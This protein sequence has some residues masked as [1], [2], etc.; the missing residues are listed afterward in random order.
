[1][2]AAGLGQLRIGRNKLVKWQ[3]AQGAAAGVWR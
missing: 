2:D 1:M 3:F